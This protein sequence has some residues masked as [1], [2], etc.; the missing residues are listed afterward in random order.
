MGKLIF[1]TG[2]ARSGKSRFAVELA[3]QLGGR[4]AFVATCVPRDEEM[5]V[6]VE[7]HKKGRPGDWKTVEE[8]TNVAC[9]LR[10]LGDTC[11]IVIIDCL[12]LLVSNLLLKD[13]SGQQITEKIQ[14]MVEAVRNASF[15]TIIVSNEVGSGIVP[16]TELGRNFRDIAGL[17]NQT[18]ARC[19]DKVYLMVSGIPVKIKESEE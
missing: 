11:E 18:I 7:K 8:E 5:R 14:A 2:G 17:A 12:T 10:N 4:V 19:A 13:S 9:A 3:K 6:R 16:G 1:I 15:V